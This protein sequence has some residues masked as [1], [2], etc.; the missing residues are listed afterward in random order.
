MWLP[1]SGDA[2]RVDFRGLEMKL[3]LSF[4]TA[5]E[6]RHQ[7]RKEPPSRPTIY[8]LYK[9]FV[10]T[11][12][13]VRHAKSPGRPHVSDATVEQFTQ[14]FVRSPRNSTQHASR[15][16]GSHSVPQLPLVNLG[17]FCYMTV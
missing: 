17:V 8:Q 13:S 7:Y 16:T 6:F 15:E 3:S 14:S 12:C 1:V 10:E 5:A 11:G 4:S 2:R 9:N